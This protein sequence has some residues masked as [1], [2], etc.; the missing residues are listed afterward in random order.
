MKV[1]LENTSKIV[2]LVVNNVAVPA[3]VWEG[4]TAHGIRVHAYIT[5]IAVHEDDDAAEFERDLAEQRRPTAA[6]DAIP[7]RLIV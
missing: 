1:T 2:E 3:R 4:V 6:L 7:S 5:R